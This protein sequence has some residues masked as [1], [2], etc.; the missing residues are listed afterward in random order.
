MREEQPKRQFGIQRPTASKPAA[1]PPAPPSPEP[2]RRPENALAIISLASATVGLMIWP[3][4]LLAIVT[5]ILG[6]ENGRSGRTV[7]RQELVVLGV[8]LGIA[9]L[10][11]AAVSHY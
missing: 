1:P 5:G 2:E 3:V 10:V 8:V 11:L 6:H 7:E 9:G 4:A